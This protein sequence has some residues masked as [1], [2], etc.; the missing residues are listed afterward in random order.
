[1]FFP[2]IF[3]AVLI[4]IFLCDQKE[5]GKDVENA[6]KFFPSFS[7]EKQKGQWRLMSLLHKLK[8]LNQ[9]VGAT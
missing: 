2:S 6:E 4:I 5:E 3:T 7:W 1:M 9:Y 8:Q